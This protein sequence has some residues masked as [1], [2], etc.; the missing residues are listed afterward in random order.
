MFCLIFH[1]EYFNYYFEIMKKNTGNCKIV[2]QNYNIIALSHVEFKFW[3]KNLQ[4]KKNPYI[5]IEKISI[6]LLY[7]QSSIEM[8]KIYFWD[9]QTHIVIWNLSINSMVYLLARKDIR[10]GLNKFYYL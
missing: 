10:V 7:T 2:N 3:R 1:N 9:D 5:R 6:F 8:L 4:N